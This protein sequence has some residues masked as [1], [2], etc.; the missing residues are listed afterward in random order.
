[1]LINNGSGNRE[2]QSCVGDK[3]LIAGGKEVEL[4]FASLQKEGK[5]Q[6]AFDV[7]VWT[8]TS[9][10]AVAVLFCLWFFWKASERRFVVPTCLPQVFVHFQP[11]PK[12]LSSRTD[13]T[14]VLVNVDQLTHSNTSK[15]RSVAFLW[16][17]CF[18]SQVKAID[19]LMGRHA[20][21][22][23]LKHQTGTVDGSRQES[24]DTGWV[25]KLVCS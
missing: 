22:S 10:I 6:N 18:H 1:M 21:Q 24:V 14:A 5:V 23:F 13:H 11:L 2:G 16:G 15:D 20:E 17:K 19:I 25:Y 4:L 12:S 8:Q 3:S 7:L 9:F